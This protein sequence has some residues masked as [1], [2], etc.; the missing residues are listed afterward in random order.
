[1]NRFLLLLALAISHVAAFVPR[2]PTRG[3]SSS[4]LYELI[5]GE[6]LELEGVDAGLGGVRLAEENVIKITGEVRHKPGS[7]EARAMDLVRYTQLT[8]VEESKVKDVLGKVG[9]KIIA[10]GVGIELYKDPNESLDTIVKLGPME[11]I[12]D[13]FN[14]AASAIEEKSLVFNFLGGDDLVLGE[15]LDAT[16][17]LV[18][19][20]DIATKAKVSLNSLCHSSIPPGTCTVSVVSVGDSEAEVAGADGSI[21]AGEVYMRDGVWYTV[22]KANVNA[23]MA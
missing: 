22:D 7:A 17:E 19:M 16:N 6:D 10:T 2:N 9:G 5:L 20:M 8:T 21:A 1:M 11:A 13:A 14:G 15:V 18:V 4:E 3:P 12:K 23:A